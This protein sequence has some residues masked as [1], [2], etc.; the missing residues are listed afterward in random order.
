MALCFSLKPIIL[1]LVC[2][3]LVGAQLQVGGGFKS[4]LDETDPLTIGDLSVWCIFS[5][6]YAVLVGFCIVA[7]TTLHNHRR[8][9]IFVLFVSLFSFVQAVL[10][11]VSILLEENAVALPP[12]EALV[13]L[14]TIS[15]FMR[16]WTLSSLFLA[17]VLM[18]VDPHSAT[19]KRGH[20]YTTQLPVVIGYLLF[21]LS[22]A[23]GSL[24]AVFLGS[25]ERELWASGDL[26]DF[27]D[28]EDM[29]GLYNQVNYTYTAVWAGSSVYV[30][31]LALHAHVRIGNL[32][33]SSKVISFVLLIVMPLYMSLTIAIIVFTFLNSPAGVM[34]TAS[35]LTLERI[36][37]ASDIIVNFFIAVIAAALL[38]IGLQCSNWIDIERHHRNASAQ[39]HASPGEDVLHQDP[40]QLYNVYD[41]RTHLLVYFS[42]E[43]WPDLY[44]N[45]SLPSQDDLVHEFQ[46]ILPEEF[47]SFVFVRDAFAVGRTSAI[48]RD[49]L[50]SLAENTSESGNLAFVVANCVACFTQR[51]LFDTI[52][53][54]LATLYPPDSEK[55]I[56]ETLVNHRNDSLDGFL[57]CLRSFFSEMGSYSEDAG[58]A[59]H[60]GFSKVVLVFKRAERLRDSLPKLI[61]PLTRLQELTGNN[62]TT[63]FLTDTEWEYITPSS[64]SLVDPYRIAVNPP[65]KEDIIQWICSTF[66]DDES[67]E[68]ITYYNPSL[69]SLFYHFLETVYDV[70]APFTTDPKE[71][72][73]IS[74]ARWPGFVSPVLEDWKSQASGPYLGPSEESRVRLMRLFSPSLTLAVESLYP[75]T[76]GASEW[77]II[78]SFPEG[79]SLSQSFGR[80]LPSLAMPSEDIVLELS[81]MSMF[82][83][84]SAF[85][86]SYNPAK[87]DYRMFGRGA[88]ERLRR[89]R[90]GGGT[91]K[92]R[93]GTIAKL[94]QRL[95]G[96]MSFPYDRLISILGSLLQEYDESKQLGQ[97]FEDIVSLK[98]E[99]DVYR[100]QTSA[101]I[102]ELVSL[103]VL[104]RAT[105][106]DKLEVASFKCGIEYDQ[107]LLLA[108]KVGVPLND[109]LWERN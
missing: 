89:K 26:F 9:Y 4:F 104:H 30:M 50:T 55:R 96:P 82:I 57:H 37:L 27:T 49:V 15:A 78:N 107:A 42:R 77:S 43:S 53:D 106:Q 84:L 79:F 67:P 68:S 76:M 29:Y 54:S 102:R 101:S 21:T 100:V 109:L 12:G 46:S 16:N 28:I 63:V 108:R 74:S 66:P 75:R 19:Y 3:A 39:R 88:D 92:S 58:A 1:V 99:T 61:I 103:R 64:G 25:Y 23:I 81:V 62:I 35:H 5:F 52:L 65:D 56:A 2:L 83:T 7:L 38:G 85:L 98:A 73:Y 71:L 41:P 80:H 72:A 32:G 51:L 60:Y 33:L 59:K 13:V 86:A 94:P 18:I 8:L 6:V 97:P 36:S 11:I 47:P 31:W 24:S 45:M 91:K 93:P 87:T 69:K 44:H 14:I 17:I 10:E 90:K 105:V 95:I 22:I 70:C 48:L 34:A 20:A 40:Y